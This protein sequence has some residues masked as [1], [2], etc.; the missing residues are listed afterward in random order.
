MLRHHM[1]DSEVINMIAH[2]FEFENIIIREEEQNELKMLVR[3]LCPL[4]IKSSPSN[5]H[6][7][8]SIFYSFV[9]NRGFINF[10]SLSSDVRYTSVSLA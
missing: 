1:N 10:F 4:Q 3:T 2:S 8:I 7:K 5:K 9:R 6:G